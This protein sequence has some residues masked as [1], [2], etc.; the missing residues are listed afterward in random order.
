MG[1]I[2]YGKGRWRKIAKDFGGNKTT[3]QVQIHANHFYRHLQTTY[4]YNYRRCYPTYTRAN[5]ADLSRNENLAPAPSAY[6]SASAAP[7]PLYNP[8]PVAV[9]KE[10]LPALYNSNA[11]S[12]NP[13][14]AIHDQPSPTLGFASSFQPMAQDPSP[15]ALNLFPV[16]A[17]LFP[18]SP[19]GGV[20]PPGRALVRA[21]NNGHVD[22]EL[23]L[24]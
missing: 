4:V 2:K 24:G 7:A 11:S 16:E 1:L 22:L 19:N 20:H 6:A 21:A 23:R 9:T 18:V 10:P 14:A 8:V 12:L 15:S 5:V 3:E 17:P 13:V